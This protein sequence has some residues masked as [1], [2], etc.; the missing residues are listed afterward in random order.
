METGTFLGPSTLS[1][2][3]SA[4]SKISKMHTLLVQRSDCKNKNKHLTR[5]HQCV[6]RKRVWVLG[7]GVAVP[8]TAKKV[9]RRNLNNEDEPAM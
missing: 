2:R 1:S 6:T 7:E 5:H 9:D 3:E 4:K 8:E